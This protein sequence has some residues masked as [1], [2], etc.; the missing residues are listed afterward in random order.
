MSTTETF[1]KLIGNLME[2][3]QGIQAA[4]I[5]DHNGLLMYSK[6]RDPEAEDEI[7]G[8]VTAVFEDF[9][10]R[11]KTDF[12]SA[13]DFVNVST[14]DHR[15]F[16]FAKAGPNAIL[17]IYANPDTD[18]TQLKVYGKH[19]AEK[20]HLI[21]DKEEN[22]DLS[23]PPIVEV[24]ANMRSGK[25]P[26]GDFQTKVIVLGEPMVGKTSLIRRFVDNK[27]KESY[28]SSIG[29]DISRKSVK[30]SKRCKVSLAMWDIGGQTQ[31]MAPYRKRFYQGANLAFLVCD[32]TRKK[33]FENLDR[34]VDDVN[35]FLDKEIP[36]ILIGNKLDLENQEITEEE[37]AQKAEQLECP[38]LLTSAK[39]G[40][41]VNEAFKYCAY[42]FCENI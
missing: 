25:F 12:G 10:E 13:E 32:L 17:S 23:I 22:V 15:K 26:V 36:F 4:A 9:I 8:T 37:I 28:V 39:T 11:I 2:A 24:L 34:W 19:V 30:L 18:D 1:N 16:L 29:V 6:L 7:M 40:S 3:I 33:T 20:V 5:V 38:Y 27:F 31:N 42:K 14:I 35:K 21:L 41:N